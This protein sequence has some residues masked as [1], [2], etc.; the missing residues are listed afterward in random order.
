MDQSSGWIR[1]GGICGVVFGVL[2]L[3]SI[4]SAPNPP[5]SSA[6]AKDVLDYMTANKD[7]VIISTSIGVPVASL[8]ALW[9][10]GTL[11]HV[12]RG[13]DGE[14]RQLAMVGLAAG[15]ATTGVVLAASTLW[16]A[17]AANAQDLGNSP[18][19]KVFAD[20]R[21]IGFGT[22]TLAGSVFTGAMSLAMARGQGAWRGVG[23]Y[24]I[25]AAAFALG[26]GLAG[27]A[28]RG[29]IGIL[30][31]FAILAFII[32]LI[33]TGIIVAMKGTVLASKS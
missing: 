27:F 8:F 28:T 9:F 22:S 29:R 3:I 14:S 11:A 17:L 19:V 21:N 5:S 18:V 25:V 20:A 10:I 30:G 16:I 1:F 7:A 33:A 32:W 13:V 31:L 24:G 4:F 12:V 23:I 6:S 26:V 2:I 15:I